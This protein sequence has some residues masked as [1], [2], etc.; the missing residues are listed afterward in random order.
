MG[1]SVRPLTTSRMQRSLLLWHHHQLDFAQA[2]T[3]FQASLALQFL[4]NPA[5]SPSLASCCTC[6]GVTLCRNKSHTAQLASRSRQQQQATHLPPFLPCYFLILLRHL[7]LEE[8]SVLFDISNPSSLMLCELAFTQSYFLA[9]AAFT[10]A[11]LQRLPSWQASLPIIVIGGGGGCMT[12]FFSNHLRRPTTAVELCPGVVKVH[13]FKGDFLFDDHTHLPAHSAVAPVSSPSHHVAASPISSQACRLLFNGFGANCSVICGDGHEYINQVHA[14]G[15]SCVIIDTH[16]ASPNLGA[17]PSIQSPCPSMRSAAFL[18]A[19]FR[20]VAASV[21]VNIALKGA[22][23]ASLTENAQLSRCDCPA[24]CSCLQP[25]VRLHRG[26]L[27]LRA[28]RCAHVMLVNMGSASTGNIVLILSHLP[29]NLP[30][31]LPTLVGANF[32]P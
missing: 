19:C 4:T 20:R 2:L 31:S 13:V 15:A 7:D 16:I 24:S 22:D 14:G 29:V 27:L 10:A 3:S 5:A 8:S 17:V 30:I 25:A 1:R 28:P 21:V 6:Q 9:T 18:L 23:A 12:R 26:H 11:A 32:T